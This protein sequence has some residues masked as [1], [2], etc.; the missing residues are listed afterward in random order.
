MQ[1]LKSFSNTFI[2]NFSSNGLNALFSTAFLAICWAV[3][4]SSPA[5]D[6][7]NSVEI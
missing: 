7:A 5:A 3:L 4:K 2:F 1:I 6:A